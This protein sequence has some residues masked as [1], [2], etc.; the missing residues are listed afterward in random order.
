MTWSL[1]GINH[2]EITIIASLWCT[3]SNTSKAG[4]CLA[5][6]RAVPCRR[7]VGLILRASKQA[8]PRREP[9][10]SR[11]LWAPPGNRWRLLDEPQ[12][13]IL[14]VLKEDQHT[15]R[16]LQGTFVIAV[17]SSQGFECKHVKDFDSRTTA[18]VPVPWYMY[19]A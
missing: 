9:A 5:A 10:T 8:S 16:L 3:G 15:F 19:Y 17:D 7:A 4:R 13:Q 14:S 6:C 1:R 18:H 12:L 2:E 11:R